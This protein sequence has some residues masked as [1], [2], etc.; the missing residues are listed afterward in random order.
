MP[1]TKRL[2]VAVDDSKSSER[3]LTYVAELFE[4]H[5]AVHIILLHVPEPMP[6]RFLEFG[7]AEDPVQE[8]R[9]EAQLKAARDRWLGEVQ[10]AVQPVFSKAQAMLQAAQIPEG[11]V[12]THL[13]MRVNDESVETSIVEE[14]HAHRCGTVVVGREAF[15]AV[16]E[17][18]REH[19]AEK[20]V[21]R[22]HDLTLWVV[23]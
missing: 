22:A 18:V 9:G 13:A 6:P 8:R 4:G 12:E 3:A 15:S 16:Q 2:L 14:A 20:L 1:V 5:K 10:R 7:G 17:L 21:Q 23:G 11:A 19:V